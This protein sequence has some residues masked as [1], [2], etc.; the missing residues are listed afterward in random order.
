MKSVKILFAVLLLGYLIFN[1]YTGY[2]AHMK[3]FVG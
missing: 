2:V 1:A 3:N